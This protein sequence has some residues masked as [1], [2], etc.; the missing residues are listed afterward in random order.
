MEGTDNDQ[1]SIHFIIPSPLYPI[2]HGPTVLVP[3]SSLHSF[4][5]SLSHPQR[6]VGNAQHGNDPSLSFPPRHT[7]SP[8]ISL[9]IP[10][11]IPHS[12]VG[13]RAV[14]YGT[15]QYHSLYLINQQK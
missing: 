8:S 3:I 2:P 9:S 12:A 15:G 13:V 14:E 11:H 10:K 6:A 4:L 7:K 1:L 5:P